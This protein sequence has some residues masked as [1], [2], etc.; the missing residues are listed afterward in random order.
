MSWFE[1]VLWIGLV[2]LTMA[3]LVLMSTRLGQ[4]RPVSKC[5]A[6][7]VFAHILFLAYAYGTQLRFESVGLGWEPTVEVYLADHGEDDPDGAPVGNL[8]ERTADSPPAVASHDGAPDPPTELDINDSEPAPT[9][10]TPIDSPPPLLTDSSPAPATPPA[11]L[12]DPD[13]VDPSEM[14]A[15][16]VLIEQVVSTAKPEAVTEPD[17]PK[18]P[19]PSPPN[20][21]EVA[22]TPNVEQ[23][24]STSGNSGQTESTDGTRSSQVPPAATS[25]VAEDLVAAAS[26]GGPEPRTTRR[27]LDNQP[28]PEA[29]SLRTAE[30]RLQLAIPF[31]AT[32][33]SEAAVQAALVW[34]ASTQSEDGHWH[35]SDFGAGRETR[36]LGHDRQEAGKTA[37]TGITGLALL[38]FLGAGHTHVEGEYRE[39]V[40]RGLEFLLRSQAPDGHLAGPARIFEKMYCHGIATLALGEAWAMTADPRIR[41]ALQQAIHYTVSAQHPTQGGWRYQPGD[42]GDISQFGWQLMALR[43][44]EL[45]GLPIDNRTRALMHKFLESATAGRSRGLAAYRPGERPTRTMTAEAMA[46]RFFLGV[47]PSSAAAQEATDFVLQEFPGR[48][49]SNLYYWYYATLALY[50]NQGPAWKVWNEALQPNLI[51]R[52]RRDGRAAGSWDT[53][54]VWG[55]YGGRVFTTAMGA[56]CL[57]VYYRYLPLYQQTEDATWQAGRSGES[58]RR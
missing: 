33:D 41:P 58:V 4:A 26:A 51:A 47:P 57:E 8:P 46:C 39:T 24:D 23:H 27:R 53:D 17:Q 9:T 49:P 31:G 32:A 40:Q 2:T 37:D 42:P 55:G 28:L 7:S 25:G 18:Q 35:A 34:L 38:A 3:L 50:Q 45:G 21:P 22:A 54:D 12:P 13:L 29:Y 30:N 6:L 52:Q 20:D 48:G 14:I 5:V 19:E 15:E 56:L 36:T 10:E 1:L 11:L 16:P 44:A 43:S